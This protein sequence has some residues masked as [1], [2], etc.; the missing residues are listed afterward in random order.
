MLPS[1]LPSL[2][3]PMPPQ[4]VSPWAPGPALPA[5]TPQSLAP[6]VNLGMRGTPQLYRERH[7]SPPP[8]AWAPTLL[9]SCLSMPSVCPRPQV[10]PELSESSPGC[11]PE[12]SAALLT[13]PGTPHGLVHIN[14]AEARLLA[15][16][17]GSPPHLRKQAPASSCSGL[18][19]GSSLMRPALSLVPAG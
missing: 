19:P 7:L 4:H 14:R 10:H 6:L 11:R 13:I 9:C 12:H 1:P 18:S 15:P 3:S 8:P 16:R 17:P 2:L 5:V